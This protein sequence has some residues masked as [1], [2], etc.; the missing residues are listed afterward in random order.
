MLLVDLTVCCDCVSRQIPCRVRTSLENLHSLPR[1]PKRLSPHQ[2]RHLSLRLLL[3]TMCL[4]GIFKLLELQVRT[5]SIPLLAVPHSQRL[6]LPALHK[7]ISRPASSLH[8]LQLLRQPFLRQ[9]HFSRSLNQVQLRHLIFLFL[10]VLAI[11]HRLGRLRLEE[12]LLG[13]A[14]I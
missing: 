9:V 7:C 10:Q 1:T 11:R 12:M 13:K 5:T 3:L 6:L 14:S 2:R 4:M 8:R